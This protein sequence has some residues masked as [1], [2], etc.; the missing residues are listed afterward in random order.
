MTIEEIKNKLDK[1]SFRSIN[2]GQNVLNIARSQDFENWQSG[3]RVDGSGKS[4]I[5]GNENGW[6]EQWYVIA[7]DSLD[8]PHFIDL[9]DGKVYTAI[10]EA[11]DWFPVPIAD[12]FEHYFEILKTLKELSSGRDTPA[13]MENNPLTEDQID[14][15]LETIQSG[16]EADEEYHYWEYW[17]DE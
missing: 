15:L 2:F 9:S 12:N 17:L 4:L 13:K 3:A 7:K 6:Q 11:G 14:H 10:H 5:S 8:D 16:T 1:L